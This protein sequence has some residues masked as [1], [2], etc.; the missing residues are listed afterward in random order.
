MDKYDLRQLIND[1]IAIEWDMF[2]ATRNIGGQASC[3][4]DRRQ[5]EIMRSA[6]FQSWDAE[7]LKRYLIDLE[8]ALREGENLVTLKYA[9]MMESTDPVSYNAI[10]ERLPKLSP[11]KKA[12]VEQ[13]VAQTMVWCEDFARRYP[14]VA[15]GGRVIRSSED[16]LFST[17]VETYSRGELSSY[18]IETLLSLKK[19]YDMLASRGVNLHEQTVEQEMQL[20][21][22]DSLEKLEEYMSRR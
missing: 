22:V 15:S 20:M 2:S 19:H 6:Q 7:S 13:L 10:A 5:F 12:L 3:Q 9:Y 1:I 17:S 8:K 21:G 4:Q 14:K 16:S 18:G 11:E